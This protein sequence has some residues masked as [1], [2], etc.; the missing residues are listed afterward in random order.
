MGDDKFRGCN[1]ISGDGEVMSECIECKDLREDTSVEQLECFECWVVGSSIEA[2]MYR[3]HS[4][5]REFA[6]VLG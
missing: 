5:D 6:G 3:R 4:V 2:K 1:S